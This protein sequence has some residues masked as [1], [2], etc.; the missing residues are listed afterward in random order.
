MDYGGFAST[1]EHLG[2]L[3]C[4]NCL[5]DDALSLKSIYLETLNTPQHI[6]LIDSL[7]VGRCTDHLDLRSVFGNQ[8]RDMA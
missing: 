8:T 4:K 6:A 5:L 2:L 7:R 3:C 1:L